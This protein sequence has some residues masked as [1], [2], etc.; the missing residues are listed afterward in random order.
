MIS[1]A[2]IHPLC[3]ELIERRKHLLLPRTPAAVA[4]VLGRLSRL[5]LEPN[6]PWRRRAVEGVPKVSGFSPP[7]VERICDLLFAELTEDKLAALVRSELGAAQ[8]RACG[9][10]LLAQVFAGNI[11][12]P[13]VVSMVCGL[14]VRSASF[15]K[16]SSR[17]PLF[18]ALFHASLHELDAD[19]ASC[20][21]LHRWKGGREEFE[22]ALYREAHFLIAYGDEESLSALRRAWPAAKPFLGFGH[23]LGM[24]V[25][26]CDHGEDP[27]ELAARAA[28][29][30]SL[31][32]QQ[33]CLSPHVIYVEEG[34]HAVGSRD[35]ARLLAE[36]M[37]EFHRRI[38][39]GRISLEESAAVAQVRGN[40]EFG[41]ANDP[42]MAL[43]RSDGSDA[44]TVVYEREPVF[45]VSPLN[46]VVS[47]KPLRKLEAA[48]APVRPYLHNVGLAC[49][50][51]SW[52]RWEARL[53][54]LGVAR[55]CPLGQ[56]QKPPL[57]FAEGIR[58]RLSQ[59]IAA[60]GAA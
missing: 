32:D 36:A 34:G 52:A 42:G 20:I 47:V 38:P 54:S 6:F 45:V 51:G 33:G 19:L 58:P 26:A 15:C 39:R 46:R 14:L 12:N 55:V 28:E 49:A 27:A 4:Q 43:W 21:Q 44:W 29:D 8:H 48:V 1:A 31:Y 56:M 25:V 16:L 24:A 37:E 35:F 22:Q 9:P 11:P 40:G 13:A 5:W 17:D 18:P 50:R 60:G 10:P 59:L 57:E 3:E 2:H 53:Q 23:K 41:A 7:M 30:V